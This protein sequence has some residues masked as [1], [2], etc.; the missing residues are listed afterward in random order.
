MHSER[1]TLFGYRIARQPGLVHETLEEIPWRIERKIVHIMN[2][3]I[4][5]DVIWSQKLSL[6]Y[7]KKHAATPPRAISFLAFSSLS[8]LYFS[9]S[10]LFSSI[11]ASN[12]F[13]L[14]LSSWAVAISFSVSWIFL[15]CSPIFAST[16]ALSPH[17]FP[18]ALLPPPWCAQ[19]CALLAALKEKVEE[20]E[21]AIEKVK[22]DIGNKKEGF[23]KQRGEIA[24][25]QDKKRG[26]KRLDA[27]TEEKSSSEI[28]KQ[29]KRSL[30]EVW[31]EMSL[32]T[33][34]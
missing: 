4:H 22:A 13:C 1:Y 17:H 18:L 16:Y 11:A 3:G 12:L 28:R 7:A 31:Q 14:L 2:D 29:E 34:S 33:T 27:A 24:T 25:S 6:R 32:L 30:W 23:K 15:S 19:S 10:C 5:F 20:I 8:C 26:Q 21:H 9:L